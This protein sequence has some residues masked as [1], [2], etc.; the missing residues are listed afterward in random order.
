MEGLGG[1]RQ[2]PS[3]KAEKAHRNSYIAVFYW[4]TYH[5]HLGSPSKG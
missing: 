4:K 5:S 1:C 2:P 3:Q